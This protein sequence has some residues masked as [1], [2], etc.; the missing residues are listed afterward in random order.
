MMRGHLD[1]TLTE[2]TAQLTGDY[3]TSVAEYDHIATHILQMAD[4]LADGI[5][6]Q[7]P[8]RFAA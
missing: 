2:A 7:F 6:T 4:T 3:T 8:D 5:I 1:Q